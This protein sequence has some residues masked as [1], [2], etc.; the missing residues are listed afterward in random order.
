MHLQKSDADRFMLKVTTREL[1]ALQAG[2]RETIEL[3]DDRE[4][5]TRAGIERAEMEEILDSLVAQRKAIRQADD[6]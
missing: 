2:L 3:L 4:F 6:A 1:D 5:Q